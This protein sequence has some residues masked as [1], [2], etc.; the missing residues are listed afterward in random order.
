MARALETLQREMS[1]AGKTDQFETLKP[2]LMGDSPAM[3]QSAAARQ[4]GLTEGAVK[5]A[6]H[7]LRKRFR[8]AVRTEVA[9]TLH[10]PAMVDEELRQLIAALS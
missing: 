7:R 2:W 3:S 4:L 6:V 8:D 9:Q 1:N 10:D 5:V